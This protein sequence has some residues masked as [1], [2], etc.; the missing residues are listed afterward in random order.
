MSRSEKTLRER[1]LNME[2]PDLN[3]KETCERQVKAMLERRLG[4]AA[5]VGLGLLAGLG[6]LVLRDFLSMRSWDL[7]TQQDIAKSVSH[8]VWFVGFAFAVAWTALTA[9]AAARGRL[10]AKIMPSLIAGA[11]AAMTFVYMLVRTFNMEFTRLR[12]DAK[13]HLDPTPHLVNFDEQLAVAVFF[14]LLF[15]G[16]YLILRVVYRM[17]FKTQEKL[18]KLEYRLADLAEK[19]DKPQTR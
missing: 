16:L 13:L 14:L 11:G 8:T 6:V 17:E 10:G 12:A 18:L 7:F 19:I 2:K 5:R 15:A 9:Y 4:A 3:P 1:L